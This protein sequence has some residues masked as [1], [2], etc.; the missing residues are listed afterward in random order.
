MS[1]YIYSNNFSSE[2]DKNSSEPIN[3]YFE[4]ERNRTKP[5]KKRTIALICS[6][7]IL[8]SGI[9][10][11]VGAAIVN[12]SQKDSSAA[13]TQVKVATIYQS[14]KNNN[15]ASTEINDLAAANES[16]VKSL[17]DV[18]ADVSESVVE[19][20]TQ[21]TTTDRFNRKYVV[22]GAGSGVIIG[23]FPKEGSSNERDGYYIITNAH[24]I[25]DDNDKEATTIVVAL[26]D[27]T[28]CSA[29]VRGYD[30]DMDIAIL[31]IEEDKEL[32]V[33]HFP[34]YDPSNPDDSEKLRVGETVIA[35]GNPL[36]ELG[37]S[38]TTGIISALDREISVDSKKMNLL[39]IDAAINP[40]NSG[41][42]LFNMNGE[43]IGIVNAKFVDEDVEGIGFAIPAS[44]AR[45][46]SEDIISCGSIKN[47][48]GLYSS[49][50][51]ATRSVYVTKLEEG[52]NDD[53]LAEGDI[54]VSING[55]SISSYNDIAYYVKRANI[56]DKLDFTIKRSGKEMTVQVT[57]YDRTQ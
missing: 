10:G 27:G 12:R 39:Q 28:E 18:I 11:G 6:L 31:M 51:I 17:P 29:T 16:A 21:Y 25:T 1:D 24:V 45:R 55:N 40:G 4:A 54:I 35:I 48:I 34:Y 42:G 2:P 15:I 3:L 7:C 20:K 57:V 37:G 50:D 46:F 9:A 32:C 47:Y 19:I 23:S 13:I 56:G 36:G 33:A 38:V 8:F 52:Y 14:P 22:N 26:K 41:G 49:Q 5:I 30:S 43:L 53:V 44:D